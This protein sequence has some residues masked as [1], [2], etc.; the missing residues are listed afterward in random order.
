MTDATLSARGRSSRRKGA[1]GERVIVELC[2]AHGWTG[3][4]RNFGSGSQG[5][6]DITGGP[7]GVLLESK[8]CERLNVLA[9]FRQAEAAALPGEV[10]VVAHKTSRGP[11][12]A[13][14]PLDD[15]LVLLRFRETSC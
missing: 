6:G 7:Q 1:S 9:A 12:L 2:R 8:F 5:G 10:P 13:T 15:L 14:L 11:L 3:A 4:R